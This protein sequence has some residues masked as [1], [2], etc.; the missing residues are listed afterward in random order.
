MKQLL[1]RARNNKA[2]R[3][4]LLGLIK[5]DFKLTRANRSQVRIDHDTEWF[6][7]CHGGIGDITMVLDAFK[8]V[9]HG[10]VLFFIP[11]KYSFLSELL[12]EAR[13]LEYERNFSSIK[14]ARHSLKERNLVSVLVS[15][16]WEV[17]LINRLLGVRDVVGFVYDLAWFWTGRERLRS[18]SVSISDRINHLSDV[19]SD[20]YPML[21]SSK[22]LGSRDTHRSKMSEGSNLLDSSGRDADYILIAPCKTKTWP[23]GI[24]PPEFI[25]NVIEG[26]LEQSHYRLI[27]V[28]GREE[29]VQLPQLSGVEAR[30]TGR[31]DNLVGKTTF[32]GLCALIKNSN[33]ILAND[34]GISHLSRFFQKPNVTVYTFSDSREYIWGQHS[35]G[36]QYREYDCMPCVSTDIKYPKDN[37]PPRCNYGYRCTRTLKSSDVIGTLLLLVDKF[38]RT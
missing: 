34:N 15:G 9:D 17:Y 4:M 16:T 2:V 12:P 29:I 14:N 8:H 23:M 5:V 19:L 20:L 26:I 24:L 31:L 6:I 32:N 21:T 37:V 27:L 25:K 35:L 33:A 13:F 36:I 22:S 18:S 38:K 3:A 30:F 7:L 11:K 10:R 1:G 28:G